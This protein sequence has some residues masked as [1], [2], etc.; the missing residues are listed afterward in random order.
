MWLWY[1]AY[2]RGCRKR[3]KLPVSR[4]EIEM[5]FLIGHIS[6]SSDFRASI[7]IA[8]A[9]ILIFYRDSENRDLHR[10]ERYISK[11]RNCPVKKRAGAA[12]AYPGKRSKNNNAA[13]NFYFRP[14]ACHWLRWIYIFVGCVSNHVRFSFFPRRRD[15]TARKTCA[16]AVPRFVAVLKRKNH[17]CIYYVCTRA[18]ICMGTSRWNSKQTAAGISMK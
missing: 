13:E 11:S 12:I 6:S 3:K 10:A 2:F 5:H 1:I 18:Y 4:A 15:G 16:H 8:G 9:N 7:P 14:D 17:G